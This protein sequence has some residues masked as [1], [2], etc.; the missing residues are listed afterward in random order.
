M[1]NIEHIALAA[2]SEEDSDKFFINLL[3]LKK[4]RNFIVS[5]ELME[6]FFALRKKQLVIR[7]NN[8]HLNVEVFITEDDTKALDNFTHTCLIF[9]ERDKLIEKALEMGYEVIKVPRPNSDNY[10]LF[11]KDSFGNRYEIKS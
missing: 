3:G 7:Y 5:E 10:Y 2:N 9:K 11:L 6:N 8:E 4:V 1:I